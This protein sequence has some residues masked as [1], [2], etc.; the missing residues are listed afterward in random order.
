MVNIRVKLQLTG[1]RPTWTFRPMTWDFTLTW[2]LLFEKPW[3]LTTDRKYV[4]GH[5]TMLPYLVC[6]PARFLHPLAI[7]Q[8]FLILLLQ[9]AHVI[10]LV[11]LLFFYIVQWHKVSNGAREVLF[12]SRRGVQSWTRKKKIQSALSKRRLLCSIST[13]HDA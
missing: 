12:S 9:Q 11:Y 4:S 13:Y 6:N 7:F 1:F 8:Y 5:V 2:T 10:Y 3:Y